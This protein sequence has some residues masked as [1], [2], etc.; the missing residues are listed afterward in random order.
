VT[1]WRSTTSGAHRASRIEEVAESRGAQA[2]WLSPYSPDFSPI[3]Q[4]WSK[5]KS[6]PRGAK[7][8]TGAELDEAP[9]Q[10]LGLVTKADIR[11]R[12]RHCGYSLAR[13]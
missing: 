1:W 2:L 9:A 5:I 13:K 12:F 8:H 11:G 10:A 7:A 3:E 6:Y 4:C